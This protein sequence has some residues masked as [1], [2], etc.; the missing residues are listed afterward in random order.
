MIKNLILIFAAFYALRSFGQMDY[1][2]RA[3]VR[4]YPR[5]LAFQSDVGYAQ[6]I[7]GNDDVMYG[8]IRSGLNLQSSVVVNYLGAQVDFYPISFLGISFGKTLGHRDYDEFQGFNCETLSCT[9]SIEKTHLGVNLAL[10][11]KN[12]KFINFYKK[13]DFKNKTPGEFFAEEFSNLVGFEDDEL[14]TNVSLLGYDINSKLM[15]GLLHMYNKM[16]KTS[17]RSRMNLF[18]ANY[19]SGAFTY[20]LGL[21]EF[22]NRNSHRHLSSLFVVKWTGAKGL[23]LF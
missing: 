12:L 10:A 15:V 20:Q 21:G 18:L 6:K 14:V 3:T 7:W 19:T 1:D 23:K 2:L 22:Y 13:Q 17:Q 5:G 11:Y 9:N 4:S 16:D 8:Y